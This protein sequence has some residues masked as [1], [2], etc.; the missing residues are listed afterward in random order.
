MRIALALL[1]VSAACAASRPSL[2]DVN[3]KPYSRS[4]DS[5]TTFGVQPGRI[6]SP[7]LDLAVQEDGCIRGTAV[8]AFF[9]FCSKEQKAAPSEPG[10][11]VQHWAGTGGDF[12]LEL[13]D[14]GNK[15][16]ADGYLSQG[17]GPVHATIPFGKGAQWDELRKNPA[18]LVV[19][20]AV[21]GVSGEP[22]QQ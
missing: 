8:R 3:L 14:H 19:A 13:L 1:A 12:T 11:L 7:E 4:F 2:G 16:R 10:A 15:L 6:V 22:S 20:A 21:A 5:P 18:L 17:G 9:Q